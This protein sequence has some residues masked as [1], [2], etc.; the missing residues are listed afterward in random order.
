MTRK[1]TFLGT[2][3]MGAHMAR[4]LLA[5]G[6]PVTA[7]N[8]SPAKAEVLKEDGAIVATSL[9]QA[10][11]DADIVIS[12]LSDGPATQSVQA[13]PA[14]RQSLQSGCVWIEMASIKPDEARAQAA[15]LATMNVLHIDA[16][17]SGG[18]RGA[19]SG[20]LAIMAGGDRA[21]F[22]R[23][24]PVLAA[25]GRPVLVGPSG[26]GQLAKLAN[27]SIVAVTI[28][29]V[30]EATL[31]LE[32]GGADPDAVRDALR[33]GFADSTILQQ[34]G[35]RMSSRDFVPG[36]LSRLQVKDLD[37]AL[38]EAASVGLSLPTTQS[39]RDRFQ[40]FCTEMEGGDLDHSGLYLELRDRN[41]LKEH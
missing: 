4:N 28:G 13:D 3:L 40:R 8:R 7:W 25:M 27:Q 39:I 35:A 19:E 34:H 5:A 14:L 33:G 16:P 18:T 32:Q 31:M 36:G 41:G 15:D 20:T 26:A 17:V 22:D 12:I 2:G 6:I 37:N 30:A 38:E 9:G 1:V 29:A 23:V 24:K 10:V 21:V 11:A